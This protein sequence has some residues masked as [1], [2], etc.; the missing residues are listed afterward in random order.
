MYRTK[1]L[2]L[3]NANIWTYR[4]ISTTSWQYGSVEN[5]SKTVSNIDDLFIK[6][7][8]AIQPLIE[9]PII[10]KKFFVSEISGEQMLYPEVLSNHEFERLN[11]LNKDVSDYVETELQFDGNGITANDHDKFKQMGLYGYNVPN[12]FG[13][14]GYTYTETILAS[15]PEAQNIAAAM[16]MNAHRLVCYAINEYGIDEQKSKYLS[17]L[18]SGELVATTAFQEWNKDDIVMSKTV[19]Q[20]DANQKEWRLNGKKS[21]VVN[22][23]KSKLFIV[24]AMV[25]Q[26]GKEDSLSIFLVDGDL[27]GVTVHKRDIT[28]GHTD[29]YQSDVSFV[30]VNLP[31]GTTDKHLYFDIFFSLF[32]DENFIAISDAILSVPGSGRH[33]ERT[34]EFLSRLLL[35]NLTLAQ[36]KK[37]TTYMLRMVDA[38]EQQK[39]VSEYGMSDVLNF[40]SCS[41]KNR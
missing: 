41:I 40:L 4:P 39:R 34:M 6:K 21:F 28:L 23:A 37:I 14:A 25:P 1:F 13:G 8:Y 30:D 18:A 32:F 7:R 16:I 12:E 3:F 20:Y 9:D 24:S 22:A 11:R 33:I 27:P 17:K 5:G 10:V 2:R 15:E 38:I 29:V 36:M 31:E 35:C 19:A 26:S